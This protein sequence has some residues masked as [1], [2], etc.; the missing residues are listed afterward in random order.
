MKNDPPSS[1]GN[2]LLGI[3]VSPGI[4]IGKACKVRHRKVAAAYRPIEDPHIDKEIERFEEA[5]RLSIRQLGKQKSN[6]DRRKAA[7]HYFILEAHKLMLQD[8]MLSRQTTDFI[9]RNA[10]NAEW[11]LHITVER[12]T[13][14]FRK[15]DDDNARKR[16]ADLADVFQRVLENLTGEKREK[17]HSIDEDAIIVAHN[18]T[19]GDATHFY[20]KPI[21]G[22]ALERGGK[23][24]HIAIVA[25]SMQIPAVMGLA[26]L[27]DQVP[28]R[29][30]IIIDGG[31]GVVIVDPNEEQLAE[32]IDKQERQARI[33]NR[34]RSDRDLPAVT[35]DDARITLRANIESLK[36]LPAVLETGAE[37]V[38]L[39]RT[40]FIFMDR[41]SP[42]TEEEH[43]SYYRELVE[44]CVSGPVTIRTLDI[45]GDKLPAYW[46]EC[47]EENPAL[48]CRAIR[49]LY[50]DSQF[51]KDQLRA[52]YRASVFGDMR[53]LLPFVS[54]PTELSQ[55]LRFLSGTRRELEQEGIAF[56]AET[57]VGIMIELPSAAVVADL[58]APMAAFFS[59]GTNDLIQ[60]TLAVDRDSEELSYIYNPMHPA[61]LRLIQTTCRHGEEAGIPVHL[62][63]EM[64][65]EPVFTLLLIG[66]GVTELDAPPSALPYLK[67]II[68]S[69]TMAEAR[70]LAAKALSA[71]TPGEVEDIV[72][73]EM[74]KR[75]PELI[76]G[77]F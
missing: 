33:E 15:I 35:L 66:L 71:P 69:S 51:F 67:E 18:L 76:G 58:L 72:F 9:R 31:N 22:L 28:D 65:S 34:L 42:P 52:L 24:S 77:E 19:P 74:V 37:G 50:Q 62:C 59:I 3:P 38:G 17:F 64:A 23:A 13:S 68:R 49:S 57:P 43:F 54:G 40:E 12:L 2:I 10:C 61:I 25:R 20:T 46:P 8:D 39:F 14:Q 1:P 41:L 16:V 56:R 26:D 44:K 5:V 11:A 27:L 60:Y 53:L 70:E 36:E 32:Y 47:E 63:G 48:G 21:R 55:V 29:T 45:G 73:S 75:F 4:R 6:I 30:T 7:G